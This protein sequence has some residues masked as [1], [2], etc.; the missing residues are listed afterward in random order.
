[1]TGPSEPWGRW[2]SSYGYL[3]GCVVGVYGD[4]FVFVRGRFVRLPVEDQEAVLCN[5][6]FDHLYKGKVACNQPKMQG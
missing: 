6:A 4:A 3:G 1:M 5:E 2:D